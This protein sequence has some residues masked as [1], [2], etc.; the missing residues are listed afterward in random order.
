MTNQGFRRFFLS[1]VFLLALVL[2]QPMSFDGSTEIPVFAANGQDDTDIIFIN[3]TWLSSLELFSSWGVPRFGLPSAPIYNVGTATISANVEEVLVC[4]E[5]GFISIYQFQKED[6]LVWKSDLLS[7]NRGTR[8]ISSFVADDFNGDG[9]SDLVVSSNRGYWHFE[10]LT[11]FENLGNESVSPGEPIGEDFTVVTSGD[12]DGDGD[13]DLFGQTF[14]GK[15][16]VLWNPGD[17]FSATAN[18]SWEL[19]LDSSGPQSTDYRSINAAD[20]DNDGRD[21]VLVLADS[22]VQDMYLYEFLENG[23]FVRKQTIGPVGNQ[24]FTAFG[25]VNGDGWLDLV[26]SDYYARVWYLPNF[27]N[28]TMATLTP[29]IFLA[30]APPNAALTMMDIDMDGKDDIIVVT[31]RN[32]VLFFWTS[33]VPPPS[34]QEESNGLGMGLVVTIAVVVL[35]FM[36]LAVS[37]KKNQS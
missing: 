34:R 12:L 36:L 19:V 8:D 33:Y 32:E 3:D 4:D 1:L 26:A 9:L 37:W 14:Q 23:S 13:N 30:F 28:G 2:L 6:R 10:E 7:G 15:G 16:V 21:E 24:I 27:G 5:D 18:L 17:G 25:D 22:S 20:V 29:G 11:Y 31:R 35:P